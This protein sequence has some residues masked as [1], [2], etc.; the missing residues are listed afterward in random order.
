MADV[1]G[2]QEQKLQKESDNESDN[3]DQDGK[4]A[5]KKSCKDCPLCCFKTLLK[6]NLELFTEAYKSIGLA[7]KLLLTLPVSQV[8][9]ERTFSDLKRIKTRLRSTMTQEHLEALC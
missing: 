3:H 4:I 8:A 5:A 9:C 6:L 7:Y 2:V 1:Y